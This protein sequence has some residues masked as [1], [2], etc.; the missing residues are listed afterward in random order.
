MRSQDYGDILLK[1]IKKM[2]NQSKK[3]KELHMV[4]K[5]DKNPYC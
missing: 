1:C 2:M 4:L 5:K 3:N